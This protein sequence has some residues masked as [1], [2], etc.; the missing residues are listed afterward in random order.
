MI[1]KFKDY[2]SESDKPIVSFDCDGCLHTDVYDIHPITLEGP[3]NW[4]PFK[5]VFDLMRE[6]AKH[7]R[8]IVVS[9]RPEW[10]LPYVEDFINIHDLPVERVYCT[11]DA[12]KAPLLKQLGVVR[13]YDDN[14]E[15]AQS[16]HD[17]GIEF[18][19]VNPVTH[20]IKH[21]NE[22]VSSTHSYMVTLKNQNFFI[23]DNTLTA[24][25]KRLQ[26]MDPNLK[27]DPKT[28]GKIQNGRLLYFRSSLAHEQIR[29][30]IESFMQNYD[31]LTMSVVTK[32]S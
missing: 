32:A 10:S 22:D 2:L 17:A 3:E 28:N 13:H 4:T 24:F 6:E 21:M 14:L 1:L 26:K 25:I 18:V 15:Y 31:Y 9:A 20:A 29:A 5:E 11:N 23:A 19:C 16:L 8:I 27:Y 30:V 7:S 12:P